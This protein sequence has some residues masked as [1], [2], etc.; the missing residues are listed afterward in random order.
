[1]SA[2]PF[3]AVTEHLLAARLNLVGGDQI[4]AQIIDTTLTDYNL[5][6]LVWLNGFTSNG[7]LDTTFT[8]PQTVTPVCTLNPTD[9]GT[10]MEVTIPSVDFTCSIAGQVQVQGIAFYKDT[11]NPATSPLICWD[12]FPTIVLEAGLTFTYQA[13]ANGILQLTI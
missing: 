8:T 9:T 5:R 10:V 1:M 13:A 4:T 3:N 2:K 7:W 6:Y 12:T 11:G